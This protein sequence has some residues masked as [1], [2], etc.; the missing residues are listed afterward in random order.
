MIIIQSHREDAEIEK[1][2]LVNLN[3]NNKTKE[4]NEIFYIFIFIF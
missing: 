4:G 3:Q 2:E 1:K